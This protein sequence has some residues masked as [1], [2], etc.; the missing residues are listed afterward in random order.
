MG[1]KINIAIETLLNEERQ[2]SVALQQMKEKLAELKKV[3]LHYVYRVVKGLLYNI[4]G[5]SV[6][7][8][9]KL[10]SLGNGLLSADVDIGKAVDLLRSGILAVQE[11]ER[12]NVS[13]DLYDALSNSGVNLL[14]DEEVEKKIIVFLDYYLDQMNDLAR[15]LKTQE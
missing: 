9:G 8:T 14:D 4:S 5:T 15:D 3:Y 10:L 2:P 12:G 7:D 1:A 13:D 11:W 6:G